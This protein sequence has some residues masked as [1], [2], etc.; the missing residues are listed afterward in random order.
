MPSEYFLTP[1]LAN[2]HISSYTQTPMRREQERVGQLICKEGYRDLP[3]HKETFTQTPFKES[4]L[5]SP[6]GV[7]ACLMCTW[8]IN[9]PSQS[10]TCTIKYTWRTKWRCLQ[11]HWKTPHEAD[12]PPLQPWKQ[13]KSSHPAETYSLTTENNNHWLHNTGEPH[14]THQRY[15]TTYLHQSISRNPSLHQITI[16]DTPDHKNITPGR[17]PN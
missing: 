16:Q 9:P 12:K 2:P 7:H 8:L 4:M 13:H 6:K 10:E 17:G 11:K 15:T 14:T 1:A 5:T 3:K